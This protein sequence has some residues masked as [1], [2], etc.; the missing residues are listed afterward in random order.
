M[1][2]P[3]GTLW[4]DRPLG[5]KSIGDPGLMYQ[6][7]ALRGYYSPLEF[8][9]SQENYIEQGLDRITSSLTQGQDAAAAYYGNIARMPTFQEIE[10]LLQ[11]VVIEKIDSVLHLRS[12][13]NGEIIRIIPQ[14][15]AVGSNIENNQ[16]LFLWSSTYNN[17]QRAYALHI[18]SQ[19]NAISQ[20]KARY[21]GMLILPI[22]S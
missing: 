17:S 3:S 13:I 10:E 4:L 6:W 19:L 8:E 16:D 21:H 20:T 1:G 9:F 12:T 15:E 5:A 7:G 22:H 14:G 18:D 11:N 2:L